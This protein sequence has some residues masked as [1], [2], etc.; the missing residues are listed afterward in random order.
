[1]GTIISMGL[2]LGPVAR[3]WTQSIYSVINKAS[4]WDQKVSLSA[5]AL[6]ETK[7]W[8]ECLGDYNGQL[9]W[10]IDPS[11]KIMTYSD[12]SDIVW[13]GYVVHIY[14]Q[15][16]KGNFSENEIG[17]SSMW[18][19]LKGTLN[20]MKSYV[21]ILKGNTVKHRTDNQNVVRALSTG[22]KTDNVHAIVI[23]IFKLC[24][25][26]NIQ[27]FPEWIPRSLNQL[28]DWISKGIDQDDY[29]LYPDLL[30]TLDILWGPHTI[31][32]FS[33]YRTRQIPRF[34]SRFPNPNTEAIDAFSVAWS[35]LSITKSAKTP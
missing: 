18:R 26:N 19:E 15:V 34:C 33:S 25:E 2:A 22:S 8:S 32:R 21:N 12:A 10:P 20:V 7:F 23:D 3:M 4:F 35:T 9:I 30:A 11:I 27:L 17:Q 31:D 1:M 24:I 6:N 13:G 29:K 16:A 28:T 5:E 14:D